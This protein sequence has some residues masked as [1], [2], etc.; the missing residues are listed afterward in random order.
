MAPNNAP[1]ARELSKRLAAAN[2]LPN[3]SNSLAGFIGGMQLG[4]NYRS[5]YNVLIGAETDLHAVSGNNYAVTNGSTVTAPNRDLY[6]NWAQRN[7][8]L[9]Y[10]GTVRGRLGYVAT[11]TL[12]LYGTGGL[13]YGGVISNTALFTTRA[14]GAPTSNPS[15]TLTDANYQKTLVGWTAGG[16]ME[17]M[18]MPN[19]SLKAEYLYYDLGNANAADPHS[20]GISFNFATNVWSGNG[21]PSTRYDYGVATKTRFDGNLFHAGIN[22]HFDMLAKD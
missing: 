17:W 10:I 8:Q 14:A 7:T 2:Y 21:T 15:V 20:T 6:V 4:A 22:R 5:D 9:S 12:L 19:W 11:P 18:F 16:G 1:A 13:A 3:G